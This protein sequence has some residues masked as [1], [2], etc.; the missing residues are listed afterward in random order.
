MN[1]QRKKVLLLF[2]VVACIY[3]GYWLVLTIKEV[4]AWENV[5]VL[6]KIIGLVWDTAVVV[7]YHTIYS[8]IAIIF[9]AGMTIWFFRAKTEKSN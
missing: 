7:F 1:T 6:G 2:A 8:P 5:N 3:V 9:I 4:F